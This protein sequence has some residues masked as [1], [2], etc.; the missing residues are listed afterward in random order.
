MFG[1]AIV[2]YGPIHF[3]AGAVQVDQRGTT[4]AAHELDFFSGDGDEIGLVGDLCHGELFCRGGGVQVFAQRGQNFAGEH[5]HAFSGEVAGEAA[6]L[7]QTEQVADTEALDV[8]F[9]AVAD[10]GG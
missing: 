3:A 9:E 10:G 4:A 7:E 6:E 2:E 1:E 5:G 8:L